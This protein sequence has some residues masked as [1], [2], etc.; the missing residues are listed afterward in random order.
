MLFNFGISLFKLITIA[1]YFDFGHV[2]NY[3][4][5]VSRVD[6]NPSKTKSIQSWVRNVR[7]DFQTIFRI[8]CKI[9][10]RFVFRTC[11]ASAFSVRPRGTCESHYWNFSKVSP[12][13]RNQL[14]EFLKSQPAA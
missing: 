6:L 4:L 14:L 7:I 3:L 2:S 9:S 11:F 13:L 8:C 5:F 10:V 12:L 1:M